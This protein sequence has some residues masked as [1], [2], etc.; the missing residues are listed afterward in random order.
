[1][2]LGCPWGVRRVEVE[3]MV[4]DTSVVGVAAVVVV[5]LFL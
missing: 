5:V 4:V 3:M 1:M 2:E